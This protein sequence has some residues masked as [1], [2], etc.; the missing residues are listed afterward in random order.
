MF[1]GIYGNKSG[2]LVHV[3]R[4]PK[5]PESL[6]VRQV[7]NKFFEQRGRKLKKQRLTVI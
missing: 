1:L 7:S 2:G 3:L 4:K 5:S 6:E